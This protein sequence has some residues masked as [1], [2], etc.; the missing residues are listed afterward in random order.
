[1]LLVAATR[2]YLGAILGV[3]RISV[4]VACTCMCIYGHA[5]LFGSA[6]MYVGRHTF[7]YM[8]IYTYVNMYVCIYIYI[9]YIYREIQAH[10]CIYICM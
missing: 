9:S 6:R 5:L 8:Y 2:L 7:A 10:I 4:D 3:E 1:M